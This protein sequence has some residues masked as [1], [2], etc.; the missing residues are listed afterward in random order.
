MQFLLTTEQYER[1]LEILNDAL[2]YNES[3]FIYKWIGQFHLA[4][5]HTQQGISFL[6]KAR[7][8]TPNDA[9]LL[10]NLTRA[11][12]NTSQFKSGDDILVQFKK[13]APNASAIAEL[14]ALRKSMSDR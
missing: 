13:N 3:F 1:A 2:K 7:K 5:N 6:E 4:L 8:L 11:Y 14:E 10:Y 9:Q 12:Y